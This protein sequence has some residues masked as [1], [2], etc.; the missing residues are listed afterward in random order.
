[1]IL[2][3]AI[4]LQALPKAVSLAT[5][6]GQDPTADRIA[7]LIR[8]L[9]HEDSALR[10]AA[11]RELDAIG[12]PALDTLRKAAESDSDAEIRR[13][14][15]HIVQTITLRM[16]AAAARKELARWE[17]EWHGNGGNVFVVRGERWWWGNGPSMPKDALMS[18]IKIVEMTDRW[19]AADMMVDYGPMKGQICHAIFR[20]D[21]ET[22]H[23]C[24]S[25]EPRRP[26]E[27]RTG[28]LQ[29]HVAWQRAK[30]GAPVKVPPP[31][32]PV[33]PLDV[34]YVSDPFSLDLPL[35]ESKEPI[36]RIILE[37]RLAD[38]GKGTLIMD[39][40]V[41]KFDEFGELVAGGKQLPLI[42]L[43]ISLKLV[44]KEKDRQLWEIRGPKIVSRLSLVSFSFDAPW[45]DGRLLV[46][47]KKG[48]VRHAINCIE[49]MHRV[50]PS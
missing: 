6:D 39:P 3:L 20:L 17:G 33:Q 27:F 45:G 23:Y 49:R 43:E 40:S 24:G 38:G 19:S 18:T 15:Q 48:E 25:Y 21:G 14:A 31:A 12:A 1:M 47:D 32:V 36:H 46:H 16:R 2:S 35:A 41:L 5:D 8:Q 11:S 37:G 50:P 44:R 7:R 29:F 42:K 4:G 22:L 30:P 9:G 34:Q 10:E 26:T 13:R 28:P